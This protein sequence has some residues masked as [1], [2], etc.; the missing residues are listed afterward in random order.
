[1]TV[2]CPFVM[3][4]LTNG[5]DADKLLGA[6]D[7]DKLLLTVSHIFGVVRCFIILSG[8]G[9][10]LMAQMDGRRCLNC[11]ILRARRINRLIRCD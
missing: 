1:M 11:V 2:S 4:K 5:Q 7:A 3:L 6:D 9:D 10:F 8:L